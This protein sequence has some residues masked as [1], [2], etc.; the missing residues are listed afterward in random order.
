MELYEPLGVNFYNLLSSMEILRR[1]TL[2]LGSD[3]SLS[4]DSI[5]FHSYYSHYLT[6]GGGIWLRLNQSECISLLSKSNYNLY[7]GNTGV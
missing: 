5:F 6:L 1:V 2:L 3:S 4:G 7:T